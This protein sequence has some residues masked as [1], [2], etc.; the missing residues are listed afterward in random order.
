M[1]VSQTDWLD[2][3]FKHEPSIVTRRIAEEVI[4]VPTMRRI[5]EEGASL[6]TLDEVAAFLWE[7]F[8]GER[9]GHD[10][11]KELQAHFEVDQT[12]AEQDVREFIEQLLAIQALIE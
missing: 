9:S 3:R 5:G 6:Y 10:L 2:N 8:D 12:Q 7:R 4:L 1:K 11:V